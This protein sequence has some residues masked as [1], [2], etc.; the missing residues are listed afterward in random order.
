ME[1][2]ELNMHVLSALL[3]HCGRMLLLVSLYLRVHV[4]VG[5][6][7]WMCASV[8]AWDVPYQQGPFAQV[9]CCDSLIFNTCSP[10]LLSLAEDTLLCHSLAEL[11]HAFTSNS[12]PFSAICF[13]RISLSPPVPRFF[14]SFLCFSLLP[15]ISIC[16][17]TLSFSLLFF[18]FYPLLLPWLLFS[19][20]SGCVKN[21][22][23]CQK[24]LGSL[25]GLEA[26]EACLDDGFVGLYVRE[27]T[28][29]LKRGGR[30]RESSSVSMVTMV[31]KP[32]Y[33]IQSCFPGS[34]ASL[35]PQGLMPG[36]LSL[37]EH[38]FDTTD[39]QC[40]PHLRSFSPNIV[41]QL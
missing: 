35:A 19:E 39:W 22:Q 25:A 16:A 6:C 20:G 12:F 40:E 14:L 34:C 32:D 41:N 23:P 38:H 11:F 33:I 7:V 13:L 29:N 18:S 17:A 3:C 8:P 5:V 15:H 31:T 1:G 10:H 4:C 30:E 24:D 37:A 28:K 21:S 9:L 26:C 36:S 2:C 27:I